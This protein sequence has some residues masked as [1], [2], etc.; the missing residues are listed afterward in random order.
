MNQDKIDETFDHFSFTKKS[1]AIIFLRNVFIL[2]PYKPTSHD[3]Y[4][5]ERKSVYD[6]LNHNS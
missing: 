1:V 4:T 3:N 6:F 5:S 2:C